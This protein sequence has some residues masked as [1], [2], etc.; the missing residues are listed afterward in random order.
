MAKEIT[1]KNKTTANDL[2]PKVLVADTK[3]PDYQ[4]E[5]RLQEELTFYKTSGFGWVLRT[6]F[7]SRSPNRN[8]PDRYYGIAVDDG[9]SVRVGGGPHI[10]A[11][12]TVYVKEGI[13]AEALKCYLELLNAGTINAGEIWDRISTRRARGQEYRAQG[14]THWKW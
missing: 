9:R 14:R 1:Q 4:K 11:T 2:P 8:Y 12:V 6:L 13:R 10:L 3:Y 5:E 7:I